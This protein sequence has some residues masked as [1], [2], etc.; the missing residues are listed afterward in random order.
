MCWNIVASDLHGGEMVGEI[1]KVII[2]GEEFE[3][4]IENDGEQYIATIQPEIINSN[5]TNGNT[6]V[7]KLSSDCHLRPVIFSM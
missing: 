5:S 7:T 1:R 4:E 3:V 2:D 6:Y